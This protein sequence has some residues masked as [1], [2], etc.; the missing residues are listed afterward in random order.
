V[1]T[2]GPLSE[3][4][5]PYFDLV[6]AASSR[7][8]AGTACL[9]AETAHSTSVVQKQRGVFMTKLLLAIG[10][11]LALSGAA[12]AQQNSTKEQIVGAWSLVS[13]ISETEDGKRGEPFGAAP[14]GVMIFSSAGHFSLFQ[15][16]AEIPK[17]A[18][19]DRAIS[20]DLRAVL[21]EPATKQRFE[22]IASYINPMSGAELLAYYPD[23][24][25]FVEAGDRADQHV[26][27]RAQVT[28]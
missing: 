16:R 4:S 1:I 9:C 15:S 7:R 2:E 14:K 27:G 22:D 19:N 3:I 5:G 21:S 24:A 20:D 23:R 10:M 26:Q 8:D 17:I 6:C 13:V 11:S 28:P 18:A 12:L 25:G